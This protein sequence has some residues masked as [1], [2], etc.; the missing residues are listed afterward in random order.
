VKPA[1]APLSAS[2]DDGNIRLILVRDWLSPSRISQ[3][4]EIGNGTDTFIFGDWS[5]NAAAIN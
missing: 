2:A 5:R 1:V 4:A 3:G